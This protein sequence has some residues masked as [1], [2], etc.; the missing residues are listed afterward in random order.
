MALLY[1]FEHHSK[2]AAMPNRAFSF[3]VLL[4]A[5]LDKILGTIMKQYAE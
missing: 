2:T 5:E 1:L 3:K 4:T